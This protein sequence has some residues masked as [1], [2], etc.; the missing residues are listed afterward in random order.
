MTDYD[1]VI[2]GAGIH[3]AAIAR[4]ASY[5][6]YKVCIVEQYHQPG[7]ATSS[8]SSKLIHGGLRYLESYQF[9]LVRE[10][11]HERAVLLKIASSLVKLIPFYIPVYKNNKRPPWLIFAGLFIYRLLGGGHFKK[12]PKSE[13]SSLDGLDTEQLQAVFQYHDAQTDDQKLTQAV[14][15][16][17]INQGAN[18]K[19]DCEFISADLSSNNLQINLKDHEPVSA[20]ILINASG[21]WVNNVLKKI[22]PSQKTLPI[23]LIQGTH[24]VIPRTLSKGI[25][26]VEAADRRVVFAIPWKQHCLIGTTETAFNDKPEN[27][28]PLPEEITYLL[29][30]WNHYFNDKLTADDVLES[31]AG[32]RVLPG[33]DGSAFSRSR[34]TILHT[35]NNDNPKIISIYGGKLTAHRATAE[36]V[37]KIIHQ[38]LPG[39]KKT[40]TTTLKLESQNLK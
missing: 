28:H 3:G 18:F 13:W 40:D 1:L 22:N 26:Y 32:L 27:T 30:T 8:R 33:S 31:F 36:A 15:N 16:N 2:I 6:D 9:K 14:L 5:D 7:L 21:P 19:S 37:M 10:C 39:H 20:K 17:A 4:A 35:D 11:L 34:D 29:S 24:I 12:I 23:D 38:Q 25:Y